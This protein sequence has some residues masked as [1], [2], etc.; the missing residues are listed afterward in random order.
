MNTTTALSATDYATVVA[1]AEALAERLPG[2]ERPSVVHL[3]DP[4]AVTGPFADALV[5]EF[6]GARSTDLALVLND[7]SIFAEVS[8]VAEALAEPGDIVR[9]AFEGAIAALGTGVLGEIIEGD[10]SALVSANG[11]AVFELT[12]A[13][14]SIGWFA[15]RLHP[16][17]VRVEAPAVPANLARISNVEMTLTVEIG[18]TRMS[19]RDLLALE[20]GAVVELDRA[21][22]SP[23][24]ILLNGRLIAQGDVVVV[25]QSYAV[26]VTRILDAAEA[27]V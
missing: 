8:G 21:A 2:T 18:R 13:T 17:S 15:I 25:D 20:P 1:A 3:P 6:V 22:G 5:T 7:R 11:T 26:R 10:A 24:D 16:A 4:S 27:L 19:V 12:T 14:G 23:A 9:P